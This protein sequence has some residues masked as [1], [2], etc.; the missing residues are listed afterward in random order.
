[1]NS[2]DWGPGKPAGVSGSDGRG[3]VGT[4]AP[5][6]ETGVSSQA[7]LAALRAGAQRAGLLYGQRVRGAIVQEIGEDHPNSLSRLDRL[8]GVGGGR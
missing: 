1:M 6:A 5:T 7:G 4:D 2:G 3:T 8:D